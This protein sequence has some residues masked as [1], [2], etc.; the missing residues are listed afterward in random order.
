MSLEVCHPSRRCSTVG[1]HTDCCDWEVV[2][3]TVRWGN[4]CS[5]V[6]DTPQT[7][8]LFP[9]ASYEGPERCGVYREAEASSTMHI[10]SGEATDRVLK[11]F[12]WLAV[13]SVVI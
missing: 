6:V 10:R 12:C 7:A 2:N 1:T 5:T 4:W 9:R 8:T 3:K 13:G 11:I